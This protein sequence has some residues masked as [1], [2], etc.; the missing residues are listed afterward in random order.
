MQFLTVIKLV[1]VTFFLGALP[2]MS[3]T[4]TVR[5]LA[6]ARAID[7]V[8]EARRD[9][10]PV[11]TAIELEVQR[12]KLCITSIQDRPGNKFRI[13]DSW[14]IEQKGAYEKRKKGLDPAMVRGVRNYVYNYSTR[15]DWEDLLR[16]VL[17][18]EDIFPE[19]QHLAF[20]DETF[21]LY[22]LKLIVGHKV[23]FVETDARELTLK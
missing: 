4:R 19:I 20:Y 17:E 1:V 11:D 14:C 12:D 23:A 2:I 5:E 10:L 13:L 8:A 21:R 3:D 6:V 15:G 9:G 7:R 18:R 22:L 16:E